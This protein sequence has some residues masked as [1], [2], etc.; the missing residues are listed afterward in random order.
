MTDDN[1]RVAG[2]LHDARICLWN[3]ENALNEPSQ[4]LARARRLIDEL[5]N[6]GQ[7]YVSIAS[8]EA[9]I[10]CDGMYVDFSTFDETVRG[11]E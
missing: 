7:F 8:D 11:G 6:D 10:G 3:A 2:F 4:P 1:Y 5:L 9:W